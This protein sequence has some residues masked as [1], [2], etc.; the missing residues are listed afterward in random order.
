M[1]TR[2]QVRKARDISRE[3]I[4]VKEEMYHFRVKDE[5]EEKKRCLYFRHPE[6]AGCLQERAEIRQERARELMGRQ[7][8]SLGLCLFH[9][10]RCAHLP[11]IQARVQNRVFRQQQ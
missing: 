5:S 4:Q 10:T 1:W 2:H 8:F 6:H 11:V 9:L 7:G 3:R